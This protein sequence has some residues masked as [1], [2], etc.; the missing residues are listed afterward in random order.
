MSSE[1]INQT[2]EKFTLTEAQKQEVERQLAIIR[3]G[4][5][6]IIP[7]E[8]LRR[9]LERFVVTGQPLKVKLGLDPS[10]PDI[11]VGHTVVLQKMRQFQELGHTIQLVIGDFTGRIGDP[12]GKSE[13][14]KP[15][16]E[17]QVKENARSYVEQFGKVLDASR[18]EVNYNSSWL[19]PL[20]FSEVVE[21]AA[22]TTVARMLERD[23]F[24]KRYKSEQPISLHEFFYPLMQGYDSVALQSD[25]E[26]GGTDQKFNLLMGRN[27]QKEYGQEQQVI[28]TMPLLE[29]LDGVQKM[30]KSLGNYIGV[31][32]PANEIYGKAMSVPDELMLRY[33]ELATDMSNEDLEALRAGLAD[34]SVHPRDAKMNLAKTFV[35]MYHGEEAAEAAENYFKTV[36]QQRALPT[37]IPEVKLD[38][39]AYENGEAGIVNLVFDLG[40]AD[41]KGEARRM[42]QQGAVKINEEKV[43]DINASV[44][45]ADE[46]VV[47]VGKRKFAKVKLG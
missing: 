11:H 47:Q 33:Y 21:L 40:L 41:S 5:M 16:T 19:A 26:L 4:A 32:E 42:V 30:S 35:R 6:E 10:A 1:Q 14:R 38:A 24:E 15:L 44:K 46:M 3:R 17:E 7:E 34:G 43:A 45:L 28:L 13:T 2:N 20:T 25:V 29:G 36:F 27:L 18:V 31:N 12:T 37:D 39:A 9:K 8:D 23:D 22:K